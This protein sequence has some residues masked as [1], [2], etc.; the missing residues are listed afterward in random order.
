MVWDKTQ[1]WFWEGNVQKKIVEHLKNKGFKI[2]K[3]ANTQSKESGYDIVGKK[4]RRNG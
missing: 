2:T 3:T 1:D 4:E